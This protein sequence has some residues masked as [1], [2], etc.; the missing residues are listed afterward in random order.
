[1]INP[2]L[3]PQQHISDDDIDD[4]CDVDEEAGIGNMNYAPFKT[5][6]NIQIMKQSSQV[7]ERVLS[8]FEPL[9]SKVLSLQIDP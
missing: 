4:D 9:E 3:V 6:S 5:N 1:V 8:L 7:L 2:Q